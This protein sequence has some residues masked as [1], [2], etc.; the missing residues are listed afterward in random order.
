MLRKRDPYDAY[1]R[2]EFDARVR[3][4]NSSELVHVCYNQFIDALGSALAANQRTD[5]LLRSRSLTRAL[6]ALMALQLGVDREHEM[7]AAL[8]EFYGA[9]SKSVLASSLDF[10][11][12][13]LEEIRNDFIEVRDGLALARA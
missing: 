11:A 8:S 7:A 5:T 2:V 13:R 9:A 12:A 4:A 6:T 3:G 10:D 1:Q